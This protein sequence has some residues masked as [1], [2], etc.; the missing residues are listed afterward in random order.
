[1]TGD[2][3]DYVVIGAGAAGSIVA[4][5]AAMAS[6]KVLLLEMGLGPD[7]AERDVWDPTRWYEVLANTAYEIG[8][9]S[10][11]QPNLDDRVI[12]LLQSRG[13]GG[14]Q[15]HNAMVYV[16]GGRVTYDYWA[17]HLGCTG[18]DY[19][20]LKSYFEGLE[21][22]VGILDG[23][24]D[25]FT[26]S[27]V[28]AA[29]RLGLPSNPNYNDGPSE[30]GAVPFQ[31]TIYERPDGTLARTTSY[32]SFIGR[33]RASLS[34]LTIETG[35]YVHKVVPASAGSPPAVEYR[36]R[37]GE[38]V[39]VHAQRDVVLSGGAIAS[40]AILLRSGIGHPDTLTKLEI[41]PAAE[42]PGVGQNFYDDLGVGM[43]VLPT[44]ALPPQPYGYIAA[45]A[46]ATSDG[47]DPG[48]N[49]AYAKVDIEIQLSTTA[50]AGAP[51]LPPPLPPGPYLIIGA[52]ALHLK[53]RGSVTL[54]S[55]D[56]YVAPVVNPNWLSD[57]ADLPH[58]MATL[59]LVYEFA[60]D[61]QMSAQWGWQPPA[62]PPPPDLFPL[63]PVEVAE[64]WIRKTGLTVQ[65]YIGSCRMGTDA[66]AVVDPATMKVRGVDGI[67]VI[68][69]SAAPTPVTGNTAGVSM[70]IGARGAE[71]LLTT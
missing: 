39:T 53:S 35:C 14:C 31:F 67:R 68:D 21:S 54:A 55:G 23:A 8:Y 47:T 37:F 34:T 22:V 60:S 10:T 32:Q 64:W 49:P 70:V 46:F 24:Q 2:D 13:L 71:L 61:S 20:S 45:G 27:F 17:S 58:C 40:P 59:G 50:M 7:L 1:M 33:Q 63:F 66:G 9:H 6:H 36:N 57:P 15:L 5:K 28:E 56:P 52:S 12:N 3:Y 41:K 26:A 4:A 65:H 29:G 43:L 38:V 25:A 42:L 62:A 11:S 16:R 51:I 18:W 48:P 44:K 69:A 30:Y 19:A